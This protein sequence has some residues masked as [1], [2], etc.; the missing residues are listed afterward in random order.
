MTIELLDCT[1]REGTQITRI[2]KDTRLSILEGLANS[3]LD[4]VEIGFLNDTE[5]TEKLCKK[6]RPNTV[7]VIFANFNKCDFSNL[8]KC[9]ENSPQAIRVGFKINE[10]QNF[11]P[12]LKE[13]LLKIKNLGYKLF[14]QP[15]HTLSYDDSGF[16]KLIEF[17]N[18]INPYSFAIVDSYGSMFDSDLK[19]YVDLINKHLARKIKLDFHSHNN[20]QLSLSLAN[21]VLTLTSRDVIIDASLYGLGRGGGNLPTELISA[22]L[23][24]KS[25][26]NYDLETIF[27]TIEKNILPLQQNINWGYSLKTLEYGLKDI[28]P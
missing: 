11:K 21:L 23:N 20:L 14:M 25:N 9:Q 10:I 7:P 3:G 8:T 18:E 13:T 15:C 17:T 6:L 27:S 19:R 2:E 26:K 16:I 22:Y 1:L 24:R 5:E 12:E 4:F 28:H